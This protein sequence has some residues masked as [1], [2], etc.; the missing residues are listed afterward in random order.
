MISGEVSR[1][2]EERDRS[3]SPGEKV[4]YLCSSQSEE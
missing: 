2:Q 4:A 3:Q 1:M